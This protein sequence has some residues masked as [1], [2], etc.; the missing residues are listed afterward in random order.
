MI[1]L[2]EIE[3]DAIAEIANRGIGTAAAAL[4]EMVQ[5]EIELSLPSVEF[6]TPREV[7]NR[8]SP[9]HQQ[10]MAAVAEAFDGPFAGESLIL[11]TEAKGL[12]LVAS[13]LE[14]G[15]PS[16]RLTELEEEALTEI[17]NVVLNGCLSGIANTLGEEITV[18]IPRILHGSAGQIFS[19]A[20]P[21]SDELVLLLNIRFSIR[22]R[23]VDGYITFILDIRAAQRLK[24]L[25]AA[26]IQNLSA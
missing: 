6:L 14:Q 22:S 7:S 17:G 5:E 23:D 21:E 4:S 10:R 16:T 13:I 1:E 8:I 20:A 19:A 15:Q 12:D 9:D 11:F 3:R 26:Y 24:Q 2:L 25:V 18:A